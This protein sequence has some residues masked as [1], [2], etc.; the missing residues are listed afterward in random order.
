MEEKEGVGQSKF[1]F[2]QHLEGKNK[3]NDMGS[4]WEVNKWVQDAERKS[5]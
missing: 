4:R 3:E 5:I 2:V 1:C